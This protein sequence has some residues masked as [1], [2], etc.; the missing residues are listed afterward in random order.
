M[1]T[2]AEEWE[3]LIDGGVLWWNIETGHGFPFENSGR[4]LRRYCAMPA[5][6]RLGGRRWPMH[7]HFNYVE[8]K[9]Q[10][11]ATDWAAV[12][13]QLEIEWFRAAFAE[14]LSHAS[15]LMGEKPSFRWG[16]IHWVIP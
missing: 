16:L 8:M 15:R 6:E 10:E 3:Q 9:Y 12:D 7:L 4:R 14:E 1:R 11:F 13:T 5:C 2:R